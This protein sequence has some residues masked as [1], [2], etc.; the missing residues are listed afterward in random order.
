MRTRIAVLVVLFIAMHTLDPTWMRVEWSDPVGWLTDADP[1]DATAA[2]LRIA[3]LVLL[4]TQL[5]G[6]VLVGTGLALRSG[7]LAAVG[8]RMLVPVL[9]GAAPVLVA[10]GTTLPAAAATPVRIPITPPGITVEA[11]A[12]SPSRHLR[13]PVATASR[14]A[15]GSDQVVVEPGD[16][17]WVIATRHTDGPTT[18]Y[19]VRLVDLNRA[20]FADVDVIHPGDVVLLPVS[21]EG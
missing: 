8:R 16:S 21:R 10:A 14:V 17:M 11:V 13:P 7:T 4:G 19:W 5:L 20:R 18:P 6:I 15:V 1:L 2:L 12:T 3:C 9:R